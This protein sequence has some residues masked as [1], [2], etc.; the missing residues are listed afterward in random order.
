MIGAV[1]K[2]DYSNGHL[3]NWVPTLS[4]GARWGG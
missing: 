4:Q 3:R 2:T 1:G